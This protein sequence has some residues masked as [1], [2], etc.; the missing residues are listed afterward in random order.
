MHSYK[1]DKLFWST[2]I[3]IL[4]SAIRIYDTQICSVAIVFFFLRRSHCSFHKK[5]QSTLWKPE[6]IHPYN[7]VEAINWSRNQRRLEVGWW[8]DKLEHCIGLNGSRSAGDTRRTNPIAERKK[9]HEQLF[10]YRSISMAIAPFSFLN[11]YQ[12]LVCQIGILGGDRQ[13]GVEQTSIRK[14]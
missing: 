2:T 8:R 5:T 10:S 12:I 14:G 3:D 9:P 1:V 7:I 13:V 4:T 11:W 6:N